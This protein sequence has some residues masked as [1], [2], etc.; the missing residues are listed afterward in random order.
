MFFTNYLFIIFSP[1]SSTERKN[2]NEQDSNNYYYTERTFGVISRSVH[3]PDDVNRDSINA[4]Y[5]N[6]VLKI[7]I[8]KSEEKQSRF[9][10]IE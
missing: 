1:F 5:I 10:N 2:S 7:T 3:L 8:E 9:I 6:G 4:K